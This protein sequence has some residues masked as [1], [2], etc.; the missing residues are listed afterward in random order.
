MLMGW[1]GRVPE[2][3]ISRS[4]ERSARDLSC[5]NET[6]S[7]H[8]IAISSDRIRLPNF[9]HAQRRL[10]LPNFSFELDAREF[11]DDVS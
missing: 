9:R 1:C 4:N 7:T 5:R 8:L 11:I 2:L 6:L 10:S 3:S